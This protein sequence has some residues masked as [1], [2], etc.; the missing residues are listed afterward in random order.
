MAISFTNNWKNILDKLT[1]IFRDEYGNT[2]PVFVGNQDNTPGNQYIRLD[3]V[4]SSLIGY[5]LN[6]QN[7]EFDII[8]SYVFTSPNVKKTAL[9]HILRFT[10]RTKALIQTNMIMTL[11]DS[12]KAINCRLD[13]EDLNTGGS[14]NTYV[15]TWAWKCEHQSNFS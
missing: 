8:I 4:G 1:N 12:T 14:E 5:A 6:S 15:V 2:L 3:P 9:E 10:E 7:R 11:S 13:S